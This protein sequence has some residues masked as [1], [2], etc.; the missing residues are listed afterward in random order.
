MVFKD[1]DIPL[2]RACWDCDGKGWKRNNT[3][4]GK[5]H[6]LGKKECDSC[7]GTERGVANINQYCATLQAKRKNASLRVE[8]V[9]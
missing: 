4:N 1:K 7:N 2:D 5:M 3:R 9:V 6:V 8:D